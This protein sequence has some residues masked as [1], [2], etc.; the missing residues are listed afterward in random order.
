[1]FSF[2]VNTQSQ[3]GQNNLEGVQLHVGIPVRQS[4]DERGDNI[5]GP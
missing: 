2:V 3:G 4:L 5:L 1:M